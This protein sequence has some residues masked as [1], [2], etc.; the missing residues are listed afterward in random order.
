LRSR[1]TSAEA[2]LWTRLRNRRLAGLKFVRQ[3]PMGPYFV[4][5]ACRERNI[6]VEIDGGTH[7][8]SEDLARDEA[9]TAY[10]NSGGY[11]VFRAFNGDIY[12]NIDGVLDGLL[13]FIE[14]SL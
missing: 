6:V 13:A 14:Q 12:E 8:T 3:H 5:F 9:R 10:L 2:K 11:R 4:D 1:E 7:G